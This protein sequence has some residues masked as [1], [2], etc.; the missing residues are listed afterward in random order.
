M[1]CKPAWCLLWHHFH[2]ACVTKFHEATSLIAVPP[3]PSA[4]WKGGASMQS[5]MRL[6]KSFPRKTPRELLHSESQTEGECE[7]AV[8]AVVQLRG[9][10]GS[11][12]S[13]SWNMPPP[14]HKPRLGSKAAHCLLWSPATASLFLPIQGAPAAMVPMTLR[15]NVV[16]YIRK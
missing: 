12:A 15:K 7:G 1:G 14:L 3:A 16:R 10:G 9:Q 5:W 11:N 4:G 8:A 13:S 6:F 2:P